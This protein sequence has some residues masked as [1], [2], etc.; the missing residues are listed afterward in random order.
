MPHCLRGLAH[1]ALGS[2][3][4]R[5]QTRE[6]EMGTRLPRVRLGCR[7]RPREEGAAGPAARAGCSIP[8]AN[9]GLPERPALREH[10]FTSPPH[11]SA[12][13]QPQSTFSSP[14][15]RCPPSRPQLPHEHQSPERGNPRRPLV[16]S[17]PRFPP[18]PR[19]P[20]RRRAPAAAAAK[21]LSA[22]ARPPRGLLGFVVPPRR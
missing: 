5:L 21:A 1:P 8:S 15:C 10:P 19:P 20:V 2:P 22:Q 9:P 3:T 4:M 12:A 7:G 6:Q 13:E 11:L 17:A 14:R 18:P 16:T